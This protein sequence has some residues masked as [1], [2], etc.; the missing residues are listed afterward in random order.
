MTRDD[1][2][3]RTVAELP[4]SELAAFVAVAENGGFRAAARVTGSSPSALSHAVASLEERLRVQLFIRTTRNVSLTEAG[5][6]FAE[7]LTPALVQLEDAV[8]ALRGFNDKPTGLIRI[9]A[10]SPATEQ[11]LEPLIAPFLKQHPDMRMEIVSEGELIDIAHDGFDCG[12]RAR[13]LV[14]ADMV[15]VPIGPDLQHIVVASPDYL[16]DTSMPT[17]PAD[18]LEHSCIQ[19][20]LPSGRLY[21][22]EFARGGETHALQVQGP[23]VLDSSR[24]IRRAALSGLG[25]GYVARDVVATDLANST[26]VQLLADWTPSYPGLCLYYPRHRHLSAGM[27][28]FMAFARQKVDIGRD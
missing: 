3:Y 12:I 10:A 19:L 14:P 11:I 2:K 15:A 25:V 28:A 9:N 4:P 16:K 21:R 17:S 6:R 13:D 5:Q 8:R 22:W 24:L 1:E 27:R 7:A 26:L 18:L 23:I 20:R